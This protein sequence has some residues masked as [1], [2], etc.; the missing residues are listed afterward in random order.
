MTRF[1]GLFLVIVLAQAAGAADPAAKLL[2][3]A[4]FYPEGT[5]MKEWDRLLAAGSKATIVAIANPDSGPGK[6]RDENYEAIIKRATEAKVGVIGYITLSYADRPISAVK[7][8]VDSWLHFYPG[9]QGIFFDEQPSERKHAAFAEE[10]FAYAR[11]KFPKGHVFANPGVNCDRAYHEAKGSANLCLFEHKDGFEN[12][13]PATWTERD[14][15]VILVYGVKSEKFTDVFAKAKK[16]AAWLYVT[17][18]E[19]AMPW[20]RL[21][22]NWES[23][24]EK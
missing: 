14:R 18:S 23:L 8:D 11:E 9:I 15:T 22:K 19:D 13:Q 3:P 2:V 12:W 4:Y 1:L 24:L 17:D 20:S 6:K 16:H 5:G 10:A 7:A 21:P